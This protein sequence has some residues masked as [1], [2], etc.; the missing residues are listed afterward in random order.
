ME[1]RNCP[2]CK[3]SVLED[4]VED[5]P[6]C[7]ASMSGKPSAKPASKPAPAGARPSAPAAKGPT[8]ATKGQDRPAA[9]ATRP[10]PTEPEPEK[11]ADD[12]DP[13]D[14][15]SL[16]MKNA[17]AVSPK[18]AKGRSVE[19]KCPMCETIGYIAPAHSGKDVKCCNPACRLPIFKAPKTQVEVKAEPEKPKGLTTTML[20]VIGL[21]VTGIVVGAIYWFVIRETPKPNIVQVDPGPP[22][23]GP[24]DN[25][26][27]I[28]DNII[29]TDKEK[30]LTVEE[31][32]QVTL[33]EIP[34]ITIQN[35]IRSRPLGRQIA[36]EVMLTTG[37]LPAARTQLEALQKLGAVSE[38]YA[39]EPVAIMLHQMIS[40]GK[41]AEADPVLSNTI[42]IAKTLPEV[43]RTSFDAAANLAAVMGRLN[44]NSDALAL[45][46]RQSEKDTGGRG[47]LSLL[48]SSALA[49]GNYH[50]AQEAMLSHLEL[51]GDPLWVAACLQLCR[52]EQWDQAIAWSKAAPNAVTQDASLAAWAGMVASRLKRLPDTALEEKLKSTIDAAGLAAKVRMKV[53]VAEVRLNATDA[54]VTTP[55]GAAEIEQ[56]L[57]SAA[58]P[59]AMTPPSLLS[60]YDA[61]GKPFGGLPD[62]H[63]GISLAMAYADVAHLK[64]RLGDTAGGWTTQEKAMDLLRSVA[65]GPAVMQTMLAQTKGN[66]AGIEGQLNNALKLGNNG[67][68]IK[69][70][71]SQYRL[72]V[73]AILKFSDERYSLQ[74][75]LLRRAGRFGLIAEAWK[76]VVDRSGGDL[77]DREPYMLETSLPSHL[78]SRATQ[79][80]SKALMDQIVAELPQNPEKPLIVDPI[81]TAIIAAETD[82]NK[83]NTPKAAASLKPIYNTAPSRYSL[84]RHVLETVS[85]LADKSI[86]DSYAY[87]QD[88]T[89]PTIKEDS[90]RLL[91]AR[92]IVLGKAPELWKLMQND[93][94]ITTTD[95][96][97]SYLG[98]L[99]AMQATG[100]K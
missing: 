83:G 39:V 85:R 38:H 27:S 30:I 48:W 65:P 54:I 57:A 50:V 29:I 3:A 14:V 88:L 84:D 59:A 74:Q 35:S 5:C 73:E 34:K 47:N 66:T 43:G 18:A 42:P 53:A 56:L 61:K 60:I 97:T 76:V 96:A 40:V 89:D 69:T 100:V 31:I 8:T 87:I 82:V 22:V 20:A 32:R 86:A 78:H 25:Q 7:G 55:A 63:P 15:D 52:Y 28:P 81:E 68:K 94:D 17:I 51:P 13:F 98:F 19:V 37:N 91:A 6:F 92:A 67:Q 36:A 44:R 58:I 2:S 1:F 64:M 12:G 90:H 72:Q 45:L 11:P 16:A 23:P 26:S 41:G 9:G 77:K 93:R 99:E 21:A 49:R 33:E 95:K 62:P 24:N 80:G 4:D 10:R 71:L 79:A 75:T 46:E 70:A